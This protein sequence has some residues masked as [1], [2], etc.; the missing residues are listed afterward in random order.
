MPC[1]VSKPCS[2]RCLCSLFS[3]PGE[4]HGL[5]LEEGSELQ[6][7]AGGTEP[8]PILA[9]KQTKSGFKKKK[10]PKK[11]GRDLQALPRWS[12]QGPAGSRDGNQGNNGILMPAIITILSHPRCGEQSAADS[13][14]TFRG[15]HWKRSRLLPKTPSRGKD[16][17]ARD[18]CSL[19]SRDLCVGFFF[20]SPGSFKDKSRR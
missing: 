13:D 3:A 2:Q 10:P 6:V 17:N 7:G 4:G 1:P 16:A 20:F 15:C 5:G 12:P 14:G 19:S 18:S 9:G 8:N 11:R